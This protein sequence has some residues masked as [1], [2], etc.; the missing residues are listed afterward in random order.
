MKD[1]N[2]LYIY[3]Y[4][5]GLLHAKLCGDKKVDKEWLN[6][7]ANDLFAITHKADYDAKAKKDFLDGWHKFLGGRKELK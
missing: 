5:A 7:F 2:Q 4:N 1:N 3:I 6:R